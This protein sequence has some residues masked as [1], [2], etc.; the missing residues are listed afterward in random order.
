MTSEAGNG[1]SQPC[2]LNALRLVPRHFKLLGPSQTHTFGWHQ[3]QETTQPTDVLASVGGQFCNLGYTTVLLQLEG[4]DMCDFGRQL[5]GLQDCP[6]SSLPSYCIIALWALN[7]PPRRHW[8][9]GERRA[10]STWAAGGRK[11]GGGRPRDRAAV[12]A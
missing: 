7:A 2:A 3:R 8:A 5:D 9:R 11:A 10:D 6:S 4:E 1:T 12:G